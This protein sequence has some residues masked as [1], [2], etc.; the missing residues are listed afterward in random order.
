MTVNIMGTPYTI[1]RRKYD[2]DE[3][4]ERRG[5][6]GYCDPWAKLIVVCDKLTQ[7]SWKNELPETAA[8]AEKSTLR[9]EIV[10]A[11]LFESGLSVNSLVIDDGWAANEELADWIALQG[12]KLYEA[13]REAGAV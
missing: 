13:W 1:E 2:E 8:A 7:E 4:F 10:H 9:H 6:D 12:P 11:F 5:I 3:A